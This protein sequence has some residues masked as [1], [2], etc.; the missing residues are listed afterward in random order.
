MSRYYDPPRKKN[1]Y[2]SDD[3]EPFKLS[4]SRIDLFIQCRRCFYLDVKLGIGRPP[5]L[6]YTLNSAV[7]KLL[8]Q[9]F[10]THREKGTKHPLME[11]YGIDALPVMENELDNWRNNFN[12]IRYHYLP[13]NMIVYGAIDDLWKN[14]N[15]EYI[16]VDYKS[17]S[18]NGYI[19]SLDKEWHDGYRRQ[20]EI[21]QWLLR[22]NGYIVSDTG[23]FVYCNGK[24][25][26]KA[27]DGR[28]EFDISIIPYE[29]SDKWI[30]DTINEIYNCLSVNTTPDSSE[31]C[32]YCL[33][34]Q[35]VDKALSNVQKP[36]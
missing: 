24:K 30:E 1:L 31:D 8:K 23:Y 10:D 17:T 18:V 11:K 21:Y 3:P 19:T 16:I 29:G 6:P 22:N 26:N 4:R 34:R 35:A 28:L 5:S 20:M 12:G 7:D 33:Y 36:S 14:D 15:G 9:E 13:A 27:F 32:D 25:D 2:D